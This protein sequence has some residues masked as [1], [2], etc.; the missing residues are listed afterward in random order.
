MP[1]SSVFVL[2]FLVLR[3]DDDDNRRMPGDSIDV[4]VVVTGPLVGTMP[5]RYDVDALSMSLW[6]W[7]RLVDIG[8]DGRGLCLIYTSLAMGLGYKINSI[9]TGLFSITTCYGVRLQD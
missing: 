8:C 1:V 5:V 6:M 7:V 3:S 9:N 2:S 4:V